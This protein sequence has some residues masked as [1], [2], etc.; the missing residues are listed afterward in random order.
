MTR[1]G[2]GGVAFSSRRAARPPRRDDAT[3]PPPRPARLPRRRRVAAA[4]PRSRI[5]GRW[6]GA[7]RALRSEDVAADATAGNAS[8]ADE[9]NARREA[10]ATTGAQRAGS[11]R[12]CVAV[13][14]RAA[15]IENNIF[16]LNCSQ[17]PRAIEGSRK[18]FRAQQRRH[19]RSDCSICIFFCSE[20]LLKCDRGELH[21][22]GS[23]CARFPLVCARERARRHRGDRPSTDARK[24]TSC[25][26]DYCMETRA[27]E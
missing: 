18:Q 22:V 14:A 11:R 3:R 13:A 4:S 21:R 1:G 23:H 19:E 27:P 10:C 5:C 15:A 2:R 16:E 6:R 26:A 25:V 7:A 12:A 17:M 20:P 9:K 24:N 8:A